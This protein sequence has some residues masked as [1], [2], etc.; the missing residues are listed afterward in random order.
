MSVAEFPPPRQRGLTVLSIL[1]AFCAAIAALAAWQA[2]EAD[3]GLTLTIFVLIAA[4]FFIPL[5][6]LAYRL[7]ALSNAN[8]LLSRNSLRIRWGFRLEEIPISDVEWVRSVFDLTAPLRLPRL[9]LPGS[10]LGGRNHPDLGPIEF[11]A[12]EKSKLILVATSKHIYAIS[13][14]NPSAFTQDFSRIMEMGS[15][16]PVPASSLFPS[17]VIIQA[18][19]SALVRYLWISGL[20]LNIGLFV[21]VSLAIPGLS[22]VSLGYTPYGKPQPGVPGLRLILL[23]ILSIF[24]FLIGW[25]SGLFFYRTR[26]QRTLAMI[27]WASGSMMTLLFLIAILFLLTAPL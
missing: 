6:F 9:R 3:I 22:S 4:L 5:P 7:Y 18:W 8:Y 23:P 19:Q 15:L 24:F 21:W 10:I 20:L 11:L 26:R 16:A 1:L 25:I 2:S 27:V 13:P 14:E 12:S 17:F